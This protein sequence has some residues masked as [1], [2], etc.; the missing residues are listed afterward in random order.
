MHREPCKFLPGFVSKAN[1]QLNARVLALEAQLAGTRRD[2][3]RTAE[4]ADAMAAHMRLLQVEVAFTEARLD[5]Q[6]RELDS[7]QHLERLG[8]HEM[9]RQSP[10]PF[11]I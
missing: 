4:R 2:A 5:G 11:Q 7:D 1:R 8:H 9:V 10:L 3:G 6:V